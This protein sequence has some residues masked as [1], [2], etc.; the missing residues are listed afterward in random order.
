MRAIRVLESARHTALDRRFRAD[1]LNEFGERTDS[2]DS[3]AKV[4]SEFNNVLVQAIN[5]ELLKEGKKQ[6]FSTF[7]FP[8]SV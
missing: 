5:I 8:K 6:E 4:R 1:P 7:S 3:G 2:A